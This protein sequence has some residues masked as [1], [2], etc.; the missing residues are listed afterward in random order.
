MAKKFVLGFVGAA[1]V[2][3]VVA[4]VVVVNRIDRYVAEA[5]EDY[6]SASTGTDVSVG[7]V[8]IAL[9]DGR[10]ELE[11][12]TI[13]NPEGFETDYALRLDDI[14]LAVALSSLTG[15]V[16][17]VADAVVDGAHLNV[18]Q[19]G[20]AT[21]LTEIQRHLTQTDEVAAQSPK[22]PDARIMIDR[23]RLTNA[24]V[25]LTSDVLNEPETLE[26]GEVVVEGIGRNSGGATYNEATEAVLTPILAAARTAAQD[27][28]RDAAGDAVRDELR[29]E[30]E[31]GLGDRLRELL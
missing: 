2:I 10:G 23:F 31:E 25:T 5:V 26:L 9:T 8:D 1:L 15:G 19:R 14:R 17:V 27:R 24:R 30:V 3:A 22:Q 11:R 18:E 13:D 20:D 7:S 12:L 29:E 16:P 28:L 6:G 4:V 21:N